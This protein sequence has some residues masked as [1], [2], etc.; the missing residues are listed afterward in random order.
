MTKKK[1]PYGI[2]NFEK[3]IY[4]NYYFVDKTKY[5]EV[6]E[7][8]NEPNLFFLRPR[9]FGKS[10]FISVLQYYYGFEHKEKFEKLFGD[11][12]IGKNPTPGAGSYYILNFDFSGIE[13][14]N[15]ETTYTG[16][17]SKVRNSI[18]VFLQIY[19]LFTDKVNQEILQQNRPAEMLDAL[20]ANIR[21]LPQSRK[22]FILIDEY[23]HFT[24][25]LI[26]FRLS[27]FKDIVSGNGY[28]RKF[29]EIIKSGTGAGLVDRF[30]A[31]GV[32]PVTLDS[33]TSGFNIGKDK[34]TDVYFNEMLGF[35]ENE[36]KEIL[37]HYE[38]GNSAGLMDDLRRLYNGSL[39]SSRASERIYNSNM[40]WYFLSEYFPSQNYPQKLIDSN[41]A[42]DYGKIKN[43]FYINSS[44]EHRRKLN[45]IITAG[46]TTASI[47]EKYSFERALTPDDFVSLLFYNGMLTIKDAQ[48]SLVRFQIPNYVIREIYWSFFKDE[49]LLL[50][51]AGIDESNL[52]NALLDLAQNNNMK[53][54]IGEIEKVLE[55]L[56]NRDYQ[57]FDEKYIKMLFITLASLTQLYIIKSEAEAGGEYPDLMYLYRRPYEPN[58]Q[59]LLELKYLK[60]NEEKKQSSVLLHAKEQ[61]RRYLNKPEIK[62]L[63]NLKSYAVVFTGKKGHF[64]EI[65]S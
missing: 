17:F 52:Q 24:N 42:S 22:V 12:Y 64:E 18:S 41:I 7:N 56:S 40:V 60:T 55:L 8:L 48:L 28:V 45:E 16:F 32:T 61:V 39:F 3:L 57:N 43:L 34:T 31:T 4:D 44:A 50:P 23:D 29:F 9:K 20:F 47:T 54:W 62:Q 21:L 36:V 2:S 49:M 11:F 38:A 51:H 53:R 15:P 63:K 5:I 59:F 27:E 46:E 14:Q 65:I 37:R 33:L 30:F 35:T 10:L 13:T 1:I 6:I 25:E 19:K 58:Y 26:S